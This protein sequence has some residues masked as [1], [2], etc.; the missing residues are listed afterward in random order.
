MEQSCKLEAM[1]MQR[2]LRVGLEEKANLFG[3]YK[4]EAVPCVQY[5]DTAILKE[6]LIG[7][8]AAALVQE[9]CLVLVYVPSIPS[10]LEH[11]TE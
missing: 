7:S 11:F 10:K 5:G 3:N 6:T 2:I 1:R 4:G 8:M 9:S